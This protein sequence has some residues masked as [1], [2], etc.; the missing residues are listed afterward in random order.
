MMNKIMTK[1]LF[2]AA[3]MLLAVQNYAFAKFC[4]MDFN[5]DFKL[6][7]YIL[8]NNYLDN[9][10]VMRAL[11]DSIQKI[12]IENIDSVVVVS[13]SSPEGKYAHNVWLSEH[14]AASMKKYFNDNYP[15][16]EDK[17]IVRKGD[18]SWFLFRD[19][20]VA[21]T[22][23]SDSIRNSMLYI[24]DSLDATPDYKKTLLKKF[25]H[26]KIWH[27]F[28][29][30][31]FMRLRTSAICLSYNEY[32][33]AIP[34]ID[35]T[36]DLDLSYE[37][38][39][40]PLKPVDLY[41]EKRPKT[42]KTVLGIKTNLLYDAVTALNISVELPVFR[43]MSLAIEDVF[44]WWNGG[45]N[46][47]EWAFQILSLGAEA[48]FWVWPTYKYGKKH[49]ERNDKGYHRT[50]LT[51]L[52][53]GLYCFSGMF[54]VQWYD[55]LCYQG[56]LWSAGVE[57]GYSWPCGKHFNLETQCNFGYVNAEYR[58]YNIGSDAEALYRDKKVGTLTA[59]LPTKL[60]L[61]LVWNIN[62]NNVRVKF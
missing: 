35:R 48:K 22:I 20:I 42:Y 45:E 19:L 24:L 62:R 51:G 12:G 50:G 10:S 29:N 30:E 23:I 17:L 56:E 40:I 43:F 21:D 16:F 4:T 34:Q 6:D 41:L 9:D 5:L 46:G 14:R 28:I 7:N 32:Y 44:P 60:A 38:D 53:V 57:L 11:G 55:K 18:E 47:N 26:G 8:Y 1:I 52:F 31:H 36:I 49:V 25:D 59:F 54:D 15:E 33:Y 39:T 58:H 13:Y 27:Y 2:F 3:V 37:R 61:S